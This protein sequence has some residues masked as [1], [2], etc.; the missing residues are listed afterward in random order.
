[1]FFVSNFS[2][3]ALKLETKDILFMFSIL[4]QSSVFIM[5]ITFKIVF[6]MILKL[7]HGFQLI[8]H[9]RAKQALSKV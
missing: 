8:N 2:I 9:L 7:L 3:F 6:I 1:M 4:D 5:C